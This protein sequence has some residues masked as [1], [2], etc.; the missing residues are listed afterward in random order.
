MASLSSEEREHLQEEEEKMKRP[1]TPTSIDEKDVRKDSYAPHETYPP[2]PQRP[3]GRAS[4]DQGKKKGFGERFKEKVTGLTKEE[5]Q[6][7]KAKQAQLEREYYETHMRFRSAMTEAQRTQQ[8][9]FFAK[10][11]DGHDVYIEVSRS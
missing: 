1:I 7:E 6:Q 8:P 4:I 11:R 2:L 9:V 5:R 3:D 10:D